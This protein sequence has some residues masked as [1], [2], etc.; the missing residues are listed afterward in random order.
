MRLCNTYNVVEIGDF[1]IMS[2]EGKR[3]PFGLF[4]EMLDTR[5]LNT[6]T[7]TKP[8]KHATQ[9]LQYFAVPLPQC[10]SKKNA[11]WSRASACKAAHEFKELL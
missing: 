11:V 6:P 1:A 5:L 3:V 2:E 4:E 7:H 9:I 8:Q 10:H